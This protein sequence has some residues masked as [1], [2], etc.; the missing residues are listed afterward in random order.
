MTTHTSTS[1]ITKLRL[2]ADQMDQKADSYP[3]WR[4]DI[5]SQAERLRTLADELESNKKPEQLEIFGEKQ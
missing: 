2:T 3:I 4:T 5:K 1:L